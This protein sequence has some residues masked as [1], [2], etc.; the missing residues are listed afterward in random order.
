MSASTF[1]DDEAAGLDT[2]FMRTTRG[3]Q[4][5]RAPD[6]DLPRMV[7]TLLIAV[8]GRTS[9]RMFQR[10]LPNFGDV[11]A[12]FDAL[13]GGG[14]IVA[15]GSA[16]PASAPAPNA[17]RASLRVVVPVP[18]ANARGDSRASSRE[19]ESTQHFLDTKVS[20]ARHASAPPG[21]FGQRNRLDIEIDA[22]LPAGNAPLSGHRSAV[23]ETSRVREAR[24]LMSDF[25]FANLPDVAMEAV[26]ALERLETTEQIV[27][28]LGEY[29]RLIASCGRK[30]GE[31]LAE[32]RKVLSS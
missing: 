13:E 25:L 23:T 19:F 12:L 21:P 31:H 28:N 17:S 4:A 22:R 1:P 20:G 3:H 29:Q 14:Y 15:A 9:V 30:S 5:A 7:K 27:S 10:L 18:A 11:S 16:A 2:V 8:D 24:T 32:V 26:L 6:A